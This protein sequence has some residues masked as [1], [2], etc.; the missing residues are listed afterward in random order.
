MKELLTSYNDKIKI[1]RANYFSKLITS[2]YHN[3][4]NIFIL[5]CLLIVG[6]VGFLYKLKVLTLL[7]YDLAHKFIFAM[8]FCVKH[9]VTSFR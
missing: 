7:C 4:K 8:D 6:T 5:K 2:N 1:A 9:F 3:N